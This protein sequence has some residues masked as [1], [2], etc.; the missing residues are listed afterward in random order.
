MIGISKREL[1]RDYYPDELP[2]VFEAWGEMHGVEKEGE[3]EETDLMTF[4]DGM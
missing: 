1:L 3:V 4:L 2:V